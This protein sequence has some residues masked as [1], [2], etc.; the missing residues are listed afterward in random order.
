MATKKSAFDVLMNKINKKDDNRQKI[1]KDNKKEPNEND[2]IILIEDVVKLDENNKKL[3]TS[4]TKPAEVYIPLK[5]QHI[6]QYTDEEINFL[7]GQIEPKFELKPKTELNFGPLDQKLDFNFS[8]YNNII[9]KCSCSQPIDNVTFSISQTI[10]SLDKQIDTISEERPGLSDTLNDASLDM[11]QLSEPNSP[12]RPRQSKRRKTDSN[13]I[14]ACTHQLWTEKHQFSDEK[15]I[16][17]NKS[18][19]ERL[20]EWL[21]GWKSTLCKNLDSRGTDGDE[22][23]S[24]FSCDSD[25]SSAESFV[26]GRKFY[27]NAVLLSGPHGSGKTS[28]VYSVAKQLGFKVFEVNSSSSRCKSQIIQELDGAL[29][30]HHVSGSKKDLSATTSFKME[31]FFNSIEKAC[32]KSRKR[33]NSLRREAV[34]TNASGLIEHEQSSV[35]IHKE[36][37]ILFDEIDVVFREDVGFWSAVNHFIKKS[38]KPIVLTTSDE[39]IQ[40]KVNLNV[41]KIDFGRPRIDA[42]VR[43]LKSV[44]KAESMRLDTSTAYK[45]SHECKCDM[46]KSINQLQIMLTNADRCQMKKFKSAAMHTNLNLNSFFIHQTNCALHVEGY[47]LDQLLF[48]DKLSKRILNY[49][50]LETGCVFNQEQP[51][52]FKR[53]DLLILKDGLGDHVT[54]SGAFNPFM[55]QSSAAECKLAEEDLTKL[56]TTFVKQDLFEFFKVFN[57]LLN[58]K[59]IDFYEWLNYGRV[60]EF[61]FSSNVSVNRL[62]QALSRFTSSKA[63]ALDYRPFLHEICKHEQSKQA[64][65]VNKRRYVHYLSYLNIGLSREDYALLAT[66]ALD[67]NVLDV[68][69]ESNFMF[70]PNIF[71]NE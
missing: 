34:L 20:K 61:N 65:Q 1:E 3:E 41:E 15:D 23:D 37:L 67:E 18:Q 63:I 56:D 42:A 57:F 25:F 30:S 29:N 49:L 31:K 68:K 62:A 45:I 38:K 9:P 8:K 54:I 70:D 60:H 17:T 48:M 6:H 36:S 51:A 28:S 39:F 14:L 22:S 66:S 11:S 16:V 2:I 52:N 64:K 50:H 53:Y 4:A 58:G 19:I 7:K 27:S 71:S 55:N 21:R 59:N 46:R 24:D 69:T 40:E 12:A 47:Y 10:D 33:K 32:G 43:F 13:Q 44:A 35:N 5:V 26:N